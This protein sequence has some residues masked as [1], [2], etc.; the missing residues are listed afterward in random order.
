MNFTRLKELIEAFEVA[1]D[2]GAEDLWQTAV[3]IL[4]DAEKRLISKEGSGKS[5]SLGGNMN[6]VISGKVKIENNYVARGYS[7]STTKWDKAL[8]VGNDINGDALKEVRA[9]FKE[10]SEQAEN[11]DPS[12]I[13]KFDGVF[14]AYFSDGSVSCIYEYARSYCWIGIRKND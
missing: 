5:H 14:H 8:I 13:T 11:H 7:N 2:P 3:E 9:I 6:A 1:K 4:E 10:L 12:K